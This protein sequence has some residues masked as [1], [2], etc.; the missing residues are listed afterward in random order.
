MNRMDSSFAQEWLGTSHMCELTVYVFAVGVSRSTLG[1]CTR[2]CTKQART[3]HTGS[4]CCTAA[5]RSSEVLH[6]SRRLPLCR[7][8]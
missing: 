4:A 7:L 2:D 3:E 5:E 1:V 6:A 8:K